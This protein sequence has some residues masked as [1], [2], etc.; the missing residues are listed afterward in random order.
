[1]HCSQ[2]W[3]QLQLLYLE[4]LNYRTYQNLLTFAII[5]ILAALV[6]LTII[7]MHTIFCNTCNYGEIAITVVRATIPMF[8]I[9]AAFTTIT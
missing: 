4:N 5:W 7:V 3:Q 2:I 6:N 8:A 9:I 1:M